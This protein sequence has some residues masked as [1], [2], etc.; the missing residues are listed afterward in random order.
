MKGPGFVVIHTKVK[1]IECT[2]PR[3]VR[4]ILAYFPIIYS[5]KRK[6][7]TS[8]TGYCRAKGAP[9][10]RAACHCCQALVSQERLHE[11]AVKKLLKFISVKSGYSESVKRESCG[12]RWAQI[13]SSMAAAEIS[14]IWGPPCD[15]LRIHLR[16]KPIAAS[17]SR[18]PVASLLPS[19]DEDRLIGLPERVTDCANLCQQW[20]DILLLVKEGTTIEIFG[21][22]ARK[23]RLAGVPLLAR[24]AL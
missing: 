20:S 3:K 1:R 17:S 24:P 9:N 22:I 8:A 14:S 7:A 16:A 12:M 23:S 4:R 19:F 15:S 13:F 21:I 2:I 11:K 6:A 18:C 10:R 5:G